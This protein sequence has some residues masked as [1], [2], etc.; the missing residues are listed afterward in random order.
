MRDW[1]AEKVVIVGAARQGLAL[2]ALF[3]RAW[4]TVV[5]TDRQSLAA[6]EPARQTMAGVPGAAD[7]LTWVCGGHPLSL[8][9]GATLVCLSGGV[10]LTLPLVEEARRR[11]LP[12]SNDCQIFLET[13]PAK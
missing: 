11:G 1:R 7:R 12:L 4:C 2:A 3:P 10:S 6:L 8:L 9:D 5:I 13:A